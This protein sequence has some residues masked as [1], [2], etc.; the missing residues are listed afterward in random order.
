MN[1]I[2]QLKGAFQQQ[3]NPGRPGRP[4]IPGKSVVES[5]HLKKLLVDLRRLR[6]Y[7]ADQKIINGILVDI[8]YTQ[9]IAKSNRISSS[10]LKGKVPANDSV[11]GSRFLI[12]G[13][14]RKHII[15]YYIND[16]IIGD[17]ITKLESCNQ[18]LDDKFGSNITGSKLDS[19]KNHEVRLEK[20]GIS[21]STFLNIIVD[22]HYIE[23]FDIPDNRDSTKNQS[24]IT[25]YRTDANA[26]TVM[27]RI[28]YSCPRRTPSK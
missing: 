10:F 12:D 24:I 28:R 5:K 16:K 20:Y 11:V 14:D 7:W 27:K 25:V 22:S 21:M 4:Q 23:K 2:L 18:L 26:A 15:T 6:H 13:N 1:D 8:H 3:S 19:V 17:M 9:V